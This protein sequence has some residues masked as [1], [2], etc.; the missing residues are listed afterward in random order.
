VGVYCNKG[1]CCCC[2]C[3]W[4]VEDEADEGIVVGGDIIIAGDVDWLLLIGAASAAVGERAYHIMMFEP[5]S[6]GTCKPALVV[7]IQVSFVV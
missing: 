4:G 2:C 7:V 5:D 1:C 6:V 3:R